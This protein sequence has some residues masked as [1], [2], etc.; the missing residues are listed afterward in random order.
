MPPT[1]NCVGGHLPLR[2]RRLVRLFDP[3]SE[4]SELILVDGSAGTDQCV[5]DISRSVRPALSIFDLIYHHTKDAISSGYTLFDLIQDVFA[6]GSLGSNQD[7]CYSCA[8]EAVI[9][10]A[11]NRGG[12]VLSRFLPQ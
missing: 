11:P 7:D 9:N 1:N 8:P 6:R 5:W 4:L 2:V 12:A 10:Q 3:L